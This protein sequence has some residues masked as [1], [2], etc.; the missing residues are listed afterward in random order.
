MKRKIALFVLSII[1]ALST[2]AFAACSIADGG[3]SKPSGVEIKAAE[4][5]EIE[6]G[7]DKAIEYTITE[8][9]EVVSN[10]GA[11]F[12]S[13]NKT[14]ATVLESGVIVS[15]S[16]GET[17]IEIAYKGAKK[18]INVKITES[19][20]LP[21]II[22]ST[23][24]NDVLSLYESESFTLGASVLFK[25]KTIDSAVSYSSADET[26]AT[27]TESGAVT[28]K[29]QGVTEI[30]LTA[31]YKTW[32]VEKL[33]FVE[34]KGNVTVEL[35]DRYVELYDGDLIGGA[36]SKTISVSGV[37]IDGVA[38]NNPTV[39]WESRNEAVATVSNGVITAVSA[40]KTVIAARFTLNGSSY[41]GCCYVTV[42]RMQLNAPSEITVSEEGVLS[43]GAV[44]HA[45]SYVIGDG[46]QQFETTATSL[47]ISS[48]GYYG[49]TAFYIIAKSGVSGVADSERTEFE[50]VFKFLSLQESAQKLD[51]YE[52]QNVFSVLPEDFT[53]DGGVYYA[54]CNAGNLTGPYG[55][56]FKK[57]TF[58]A[59]AQRAFK[60]W[61]KNSLFNESD[62]RKYAG[63]QLSFWAYAEEQ[64]TFYY[65]KMDLYWT[66]TLNAQVTIPAKTW[67]YVSFTISQNDF[68]YITCLSASGSFYYINLAVCDVS[69]DGAD[70]SDINDSIALF[71]ES[72]IAEIK[73]SGDVDL[74]EGQKLRYIELLSGLISE[75]QMQ[76]LSGYSTYLSRKQAF[77]ADYTVFKD[78]NTLSGISEYSY[79]FGASSNFSI[80]QDETYGNV[81][82][83]KTYAGGNNVHSVF[84]YTCEGIDFDSVQTDGVRFS[85]YNGGEDAKN[86][87]GEIDGK[88]NTSVAVLKAKCWTDIVIPFESLKQ[89][90]YFGILNCEKG[91]EYKFSMI[92]AVNL[93]ARI[94]AAEQKIAAIG[95]VTASSGD[96]ILSAREAAN[97]VPESVRA[98]KISNYAT[99]TAAE[100][101]FKELAQAA[102]K[103]D[104]A[105]KAVQTKI[106]AF[107]SAYG[108][109]TKGGIFNVLGTIISDRKAITAA[110]EKLSYF[111]QLGVNNYNE[112]MSLDNFAVFQDYSTATS[113][114]RNVWGTPT[115]GYGGMG[116]SNATYT[117]QYG[118]CVSLGLAAGQTTFTLNYEL[119]ESVPASYKYVSFAVQNQRTANLTLK[120]WANAGWKQIGETLIDGGK[121]GEWHVITVP[122]ADFVNSNNIFYVDF[123]AALVAGNTNIWFS[124]LVAHN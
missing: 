39:T 58:S 14:V 31:S 112:S 60:W 114:S 115:S 100:Q 8:N 106:D 107:R 44:P 70:Y 94:T 120:L 71:T 72:K 45:S 117:S 101:Q 43:W 10:A 9:G 104:A 108:S 103:T 2:V 62:I 18:T 26:I 48:E 59:D 90:G 21:A 57:L 80:V 5:I 116:F 85:V 95:T 36:I 1:A 73:T 99:L 102:G 34:V 41:Y 33:V 75:E 3:G 4:L 98:Q 61:C 65:W 15:Q 42:K 46:K 25:G 110:Y 50:H 40:G 37:K 64:T 111:Q 74:I 66:R 119:K 89:S 6:L 29:K 122:M 56:N 54:E 19:A 35:S 79:M 67:T 51:P 77:E 28:A 123:D 63:S 22:V 105:V 13:A 88:L 68:D 53:E 55:Y 97:T 113:G 30:T 81:L 32:S 23:L 16:V 12:T 24:E 109:L 17:T 93:S 121:T 92:Y 76:G 124:P 7:D 27:I 82:S 69:H 87:F 84:S 11:S 78:M 38:Q 118:Q 83:A 49:S 91:V 47:D 52:A 86:L 96:L 20:Y